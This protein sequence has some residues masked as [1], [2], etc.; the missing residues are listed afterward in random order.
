M[1]GFMVMVAPGSAGGRGSGILFRDTAGITGDHVN[2]MTLAARGLVAAAL[3]LSR[4]CALDLPPSAGA[5]TLPGR[6]IMFANVEAYGCAGTGISAAERAQT[7]RRLG[8]LV[9]SPADF[10]T[11]GHI[12][13]TVVPD[14]AGFAGPLS[15]VALRYAARESG[16]LAISWSDILDD[17]GEVASTDHCRALARR[18]G[19]RIVDVEAGEVMAPAALELVDG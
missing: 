15:E 4:A 3:P 7:L 16:A 1:D 6:P 10:V 12:I 14:R 2:F 13:V 11:P 17:A 18:H 8:A 5:R 19:L 9:A